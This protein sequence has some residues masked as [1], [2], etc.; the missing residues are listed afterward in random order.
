MKYHLRLVIFL[1]KNFLSLLFVFY[2]SVLR[3]AFDSFD[4]EKSGSIPTDMVAD[5]LRLMGQPFNKKI[6]DELIEEV[7]ADSK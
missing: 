5:I 7:D 3:K 6:L 2:F 1:L 4:R